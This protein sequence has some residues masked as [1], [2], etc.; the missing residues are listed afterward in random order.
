MKENESKFFLRNWSWNDGAS[1]QSYFWLT[2]DHKICF[3]RNEG[4]LEYSSFNWKRSNKKDY[5]SSTEQD[6]HQLLPYMSWPSPP[7][8]MR[9]GYGE[10]RIKNPR[11]PKKKIHSLKLSIEKQQGGRDG[12]PNTLWKH[13]SRPTWVSHTLASA[14]PIIREHIFLWQKE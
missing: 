8:V 12:R 10:S 6:K 14:G 5:L 7:S 3:E 2:W 11:K 1:I 4:W 13:V 9:R